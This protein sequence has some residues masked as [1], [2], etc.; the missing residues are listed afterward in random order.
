MRRFPRCCATSP[1]TNSASRTSCTGLIRRLTS[2][3]IF[4][5]TFSFKSSFCAVSGLSCRLYA[6]VFGLH[7]ALHYA[8]GGGLAREVVGVSCYFAR[9][10]SSPVGAFRHLWSL[11]QVST[12]GRTMWWTHQTD[13]AWVA[14][15]IASGSLDVHRGLNVLH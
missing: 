11:P 13:C 8:L 2:D 10:R 5:P 3:H 14:V 7:G 1:R 12:D 4:F 9:A 15:S 6:G